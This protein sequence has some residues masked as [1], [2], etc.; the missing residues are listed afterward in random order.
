MNFIKRFLN[1]EDGQDGVEYALLI[2]FV[3]VAIIAA[4]TQFTTAFSG[5]WGDA[6]GAV[7][8]AGTAASAL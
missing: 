1:E 4:A 2:G 5:F 6:G 7:T 8:K 3:S